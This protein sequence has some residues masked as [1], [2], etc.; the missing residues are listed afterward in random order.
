MSS[1]RLSPPSIRVKAPF[2]LPHNII[3]PRFLD[4]MKEDILKVI[5]ESTQSSKILNCLNST[6][7]SLI[8]K[9]YRMMSHLRTLEPCHAIM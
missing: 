8:P 4:I 5:R 7:L 3:L 2:G 9:K 1:Y 6:I